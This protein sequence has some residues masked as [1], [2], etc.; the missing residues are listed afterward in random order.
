[1][2]TP[3]ANGVPFKCSD[4]LQGILGLDR[5]GDVL[6]TFLEQ[7]APNS[8][9]IFAFA[10]RDEE[11]EEGENLFS[12]G[13]FAGLDPEHIIWMN[14][15][16]GKNKDSMFR[17]E[18]PYVSYKNYKMGL[19]NGHSMAVDT[20]SAIGILPKR[21]MSRLFFIER[22]FKRGI[23]PWG[24]THVFDTTKYPGN[25]PPA[26]AIPMGGIEW[27]SD[28]MDL[29]TKL[30]PKSSFDGPEVD[31]GSYWPTF[32]SSGE[33]Q[34]NIAS[35]DVS[36]IPS[37][38]GQTFLKKL[39]GVVFDFT[40]NKERVGFVP[41]YQSKSATGL[42]NPLTATSRSGPSQAQK[43]YNKYSYIMASLFVTIV[44]RSVWI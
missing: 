12:L 11:K 16:S 29:E 26:M 31:V 21:F 43:L 35:R 1:M 2:S 39:K 8:T 9:A 28:L 20:G 32:W 6:K 42:V 7:R 27:L 14:H 5:N 19:P 4:S 30:L 24:T 13:G 18:T 44:F 17:L 22:A 25:R 38:V 40:P 10:Y 3:S 23:F 33:L 15:K 37:I 36:L 34:Y 41:R